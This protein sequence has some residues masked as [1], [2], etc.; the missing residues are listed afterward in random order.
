MNNLLNVKDL[1]LK[2]RSTGNSVLKNISFGLNEKEIL[3][4]VGESGSGK[5]LLSQAIVNW[6]PE[7]LEISSGHIDFLGKKMNEMSEKK[8]L[9][10]E[11]L[12]I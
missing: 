10:V 8:I 12:P 5:T 6:L 9:E 7:N 3:G 4:V 11:K 1:S 2:D